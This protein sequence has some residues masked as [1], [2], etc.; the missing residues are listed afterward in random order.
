MRREALRSRAGTASTSQALIE[1]GGAGQ[2]AALVL[3]IPIWIFFFSVK[4]N[5]L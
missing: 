4:M 2:K 1:F 3:F 5:N